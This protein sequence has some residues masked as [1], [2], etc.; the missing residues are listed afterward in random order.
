MGVTGRKLRELR[1]GLS[2]PVGA[3]GEESPAGSREA[4]KFQGRAE[5]EGCREGGYPPWLE[6]AA[7]L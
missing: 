7:C 1:V 4:L 3:C 2:L 5:V 6:L